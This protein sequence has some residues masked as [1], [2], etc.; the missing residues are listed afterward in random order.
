METKKK[1]V[2]ANDGLADDQDHDDDK[3]TTLGIYL[4]TFS[5]FVDHYANIQ[6]I[7]SQLLRS[8]VL[9]LVC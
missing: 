9:W 1:D 6:I 4:F 5:T 8:A 7:F 2:L 3:I